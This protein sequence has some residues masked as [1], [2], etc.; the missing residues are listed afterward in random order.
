[1]AYSANAETTSDGY[2]LTFRHNASGILIEVIFAGVDV[3]FPTP[4]RATKDTVMQATLDRLVALPGATL[5]SAQRQINFTSN[6]T[7]T[8]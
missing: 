5:V 2:K 3:G 4:S 1:M 7:P 8:P 6:I